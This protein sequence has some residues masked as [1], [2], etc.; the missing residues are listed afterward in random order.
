MPEKGPIRRFLSERKTIVLDEPL[1]KKLGGNPGSPVLLEYNGELIGLKEAKRREWT[2]K[3]YSPS[4]QDMALTLAEEWA[5]R[6]SSF[7]V[8]VIKEPEYRARAYR[9]LYKTGLDEVAERWI[10]AMGK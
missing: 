5:D 7:V 8:G 9:E 3:G 4:L 6:M 10:T 2:A 1:V